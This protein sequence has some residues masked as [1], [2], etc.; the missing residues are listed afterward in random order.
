MNILSRPSKEV[1][2][3]ILSEAGLP[4]S[5]ITAEHLAY[6][7]GHGA[8]REPDGIV[9]IEP[10][11]KAALLRSLAVVPSRRGTGVG[12]L[13]VKYIEQWALQQGI[14]S[15]Y[16]L[17]T[18]AE[19]FFAHLG[20]VRASREEAPLSIQNTKEF[21]FLCPASSAFMI[22]QLQVNPPL[23]RTHATTACAG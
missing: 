21:S 12:T 16:L 4:V 6:F 10:Y 5:D 15:L 2:E 3:R 14:E 9:G 18:T 1:V 19:P 23:N 17:T 8:E 7:F 22:K 13:L 20:Y 11:G